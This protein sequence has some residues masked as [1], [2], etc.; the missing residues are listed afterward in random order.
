MNNIIKFFEIILNAIISALPSIIITKNP[1]LF[2]L[3]FFGP[4]I[5]ILIYILYRY[6]KKIE[7]LKYIITSYNFNKSDI[8]CNICFESNTILFNKKD[9]SC[10]IC[11]F[12]CCILCYINHYNKNDSC[13]ICRNKINLN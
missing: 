9:S 8:E 10:N 4:Y 2:I 13:P 3:G 1:R 7:L 11:N 12:K 6:K 5:N